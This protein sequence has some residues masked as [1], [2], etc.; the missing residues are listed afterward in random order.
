[1]GTAYF[2]KMFLAVLVAGCAPRHIIG[3]KSILFLA[4]VAYP[5]RELIYLAV[6]L[7]SL[8]SSL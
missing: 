4:E 7:T 6:V 3:N 2:I 5:V 1:M 8:C